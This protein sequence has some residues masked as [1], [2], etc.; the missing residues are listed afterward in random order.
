MLE[1]VA[2]KLDVDATIDGVPYKAGTTARL[3]VKRYR[4]VA[5]GT[6][7]FIDIKVACSLRTSPELGC[8]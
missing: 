2:V 6:T 7:Q 4:V 5:D 1:T 8:Y 3:K